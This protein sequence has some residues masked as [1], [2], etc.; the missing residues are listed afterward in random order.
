MAVV[1]HKGE[2]YYNVVSAL[3]MGVIKLPKRRGSSKK[4]F[5]TKRWIVLLVIV[6]AIFIGIDFNIRPLVKSIIEN[7]AQ[8][9]ATNVINQVVEEEFSSSSDVYSQLVDIQKDQDGQVQSISTNA[10]NTNILKSKISRKI[11]ENLSTTE[12][13]IVKIPLGT[14]TSTEILSGRGPIIDMKISMPSSAIIDFK[15][16]FESAGINQTKHRI[17]LEVNTKVNAL[18]PG[19]PVVTNVQTTVLVSETI[20]VGSAPNVFANLNSANAGAIS[21]LSHM[22]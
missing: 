11:Q 8:V 13:R 3:L 22:E 5:I 1:S 17:Y 4:W 18:V 7:K 15:S 21:G 19:Y 10:V 9:E 2:I 16:T 14:L 20:I 12:P 6:L